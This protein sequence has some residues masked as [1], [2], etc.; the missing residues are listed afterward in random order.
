MAPPKIKFRLNI[1]LRRSR[2][3]VDGRSG[4]F[5][6]VGGGVARGAWSGYPMGLRMTAWPRL[7]AWVRRPGCVGQGHRVVRRRD[8]DERF[9]RFI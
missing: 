2:A 1:I 8:Y 5:V 7:L 3:R 6:R 9:K 4:S